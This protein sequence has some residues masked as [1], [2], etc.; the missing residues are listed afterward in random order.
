MGPAAFRRLC[1]ETLHFHAIFPSQPPAAFRRLCVETKFLA[2][3]SRFIFPAAFRRLCV[4][5]C[6]FSTCSTCPSQPPSGGCV[7][8]Q[9]L[10][11]L[12]VSLVSQ[13]PSGG[14]VLKQTVT[15][16]LRNMNGPAAFRRLCVETSCY[17]RIYDKA[18]ASRLQAAVC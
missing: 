17:A 15:V 16:K 10:I 1:V 18:K 6:T 2:S 3:S 14:C 8:K 13:P 5:T 12:G 7:L 11:G 9:V 4:E